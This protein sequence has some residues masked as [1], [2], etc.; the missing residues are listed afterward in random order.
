MRQRV[1][2]T[3]DPKHYEGLAGFRYAL[4]RFLAA[5]EAISRRAG[6]TQSQ[7]Q[8]M[9]T[10]RTWPHAAMTIKD[11]SEQ[12]LLTHHAT[13]QLVNRL[14]RAGLAER[15]ASSTDRRSVLLKLT[16]HGVTLVDAL[17]AQHLEEVLRQQPL[18]AKSLSQLG[19]AGSSGKSSADRS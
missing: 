8:A 15:T 12:L 6:V 18:L 1:V 13:V 16:P 4:R 14:A 7:Y 9:L 19:K 3:L 10:V 5:S 17:A 11:L 2:M